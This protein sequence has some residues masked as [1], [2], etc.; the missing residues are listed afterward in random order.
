M[1]PRL[2]IHCVLTLLECACHLFNSNLSTPLAILTEVD[3]T[4]L[5]PP[6]CQAKQAKILQST[7]IR[8]CILLDTFIAILEPVSVWIHF[9]CP[10]VY[11]GTDMWGVV[12]PVTST[13]AC[14]LPF[15]CW[16]YLMGLYLLFSWL[17]PISVS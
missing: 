6:F 12:F 14:I 7:P 17:H 4:T 11:A 8:L 1:H 16:K 3:H 13:V 5:T 2:K 15:L 9:S 10:K